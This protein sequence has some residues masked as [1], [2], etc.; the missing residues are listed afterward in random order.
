MTPETFRALCC[1]VSGYAPSDLRCRDRISERLD[2]DY[3]AVRRMDK[4]KQPIADTLA[5]EIWRMAEERRAELG[6][7]IDELRGQ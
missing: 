5:A 4:G 7:L 3:R 2:I 1:A 6:G